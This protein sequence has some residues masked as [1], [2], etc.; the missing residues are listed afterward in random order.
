MSDG[1]RLPRLL[2]IGDI[3]IA[4]TSASEV[5]LYRLLQPYPPSQLAA[6]CGVR[7]GVTMLPG[8]AYHHWGAAWPRLLRSRVAAEYI[9]W[10]AWKYYEVPPQIAN[11]ATLF[12]PDA[13]LTISHVSAWLCA[14]QLA[15]RRRIPLHIIAHDDAD[16]ANRFP[17]WSWPWA[18]NKFGQ[19]YRAARSRF[20]ISDT[21]AET[22]ERRFGAPGS[23]I[24]PT[25]AASIGEVAVAPRVTRPGRELVFGY[26]GSINS[27]PQLDQILEFARI[28]GQSGHR[29]IAY[30]PQHETLRAIAATV[31]SFELRAPVASAELGQVLR[32]VVDCL[33]L[34]QPLDDSERVAAATAFPSKWAD[35]SSFGLPLLVW[36][37]PWSAS[38]QF[39]HKHPRAAELVTTAHAEDVARAIERLAQSTGRRVEL[40]EGLIAEGRTVFS[41]DA[42]WATFSA[43]LQA[44]RPA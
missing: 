15:E 26:G 3:S 21:M 19:A 43:A 10:R 14:W 31:P 39:V 7:A 41:P 4:D 23:V 18:E 30:T 22:Y 17:R 34:P 35:Y 42:A 20:C 6:V 44:E 5:L 8:V 36:A 16:Y 2:Y 24:Y 9:L 25:R 27:Q 1:A 12:K 29:L 33:F 11:I 32:E 13:I 40:A 37:P 38:A 28:A